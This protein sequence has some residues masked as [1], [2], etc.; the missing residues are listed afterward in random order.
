MTETEGY[1]AMV[2]DDTESRDRF[3]TIDGAEPRSV[4][5]YLTRHSPRSSFSQLAA[6]NI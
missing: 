2:R 6:A 5:T 3:E 1:D 4:G